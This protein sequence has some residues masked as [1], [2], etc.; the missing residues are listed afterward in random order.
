M[1]LL[2]WIADKEAQ[3][4]KGRDRKYESIVTRTMGGVEVVMVTDARS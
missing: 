1:K 2:S 4:A 3:G